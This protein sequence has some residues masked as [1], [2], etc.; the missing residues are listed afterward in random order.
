MSSCLDIGCHSDIGGGSYNDK[1]NNNLSLIP[2][3][4]MIKE[5][6]INTDI[7]FDHGYL[8]TLGI[9]LLDLACELARE[10]IDVRTRGFDIKVL[11]AIARG[12]TKQFRGRQ[13]AV[14]LQPRVVDHCHAPPLLTASKALTRAKARSDYLGAIYDQLIPKASCW[15]FEFLPLV[16]GYQQ[17]DGTWIYRR[18]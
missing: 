15:L 1:I 5:C 16:A 10:G 4:W 13:S 14:A 8:K 9:N 17:E 12:G 6:L 11:I 7:M 18:M 2:L 3:R